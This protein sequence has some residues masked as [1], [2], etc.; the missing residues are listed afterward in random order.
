MPLTSRNIWSEILTKK[1][2]IDIIFIPG[3]LNHIHLKT[4]KI[5]AIN[6]F[7]LNKL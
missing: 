1:N 3:S 2:F 6:L 7:K 5:E 4:F